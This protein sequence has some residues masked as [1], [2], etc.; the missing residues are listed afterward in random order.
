MVNQIFFE[1]VYTHEN[2][3]SRF[4]CTK[5]ELKST[6]QMLKEYNVDF[7][8]LEITPWRINLW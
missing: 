3:L 8:L 6:I 1:I 4:Q 5:E 2:G 7:H